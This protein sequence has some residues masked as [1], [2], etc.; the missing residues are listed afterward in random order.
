MLFLDSLDK[1]LKRCIH[2]F[3]KK[4]FI[5]L[6]YSTKHANLWVGCVVPLNESYCFVL[7][8]CRKQKDLQNL[9]DCLA[10]HQPNTRLVC[11]PTYLNVSVLCKIKNGN[12]NMNIYEIKKFAKLKGSQLDAFCHKPYCT[13]PC[14]NSNLAILKT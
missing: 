12:K 1:L 11:W 8:N 6:R 13:V 2:Y 7:A 3:S 9:L 10:I 4:T 5:I 14:I